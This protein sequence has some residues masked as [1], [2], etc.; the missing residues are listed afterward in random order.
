MSMSIDSESYGSFNGSADVPIFY[1]HI[2]AAPE[3]GRILIAHGL[4]EHSGRYHHVMERL[5]KKGLS[6]WALDHRGHGQSGGKR[7]H[8]LAFDHFIED[9]QQMMKIV[10]TDMPDNMKCFLLG[11][12]M[13]GLIVLNYAEKHPHMIDGLI[14]SSPGL[15]PA[16]GIPLIK[17][18]AG[19]IMSK[20]R[21]SMALNNEVDSRFLSHDSTVVSD[22][23]N[24]PLVHPWITAR[25]FT[26]YVDAMADTIRSAPSLKTPILMQV[27]G[28]DHLV[29]P[30]ASRQFFDSLTVSD[31]TLHFYDG[32]YHE[33]YNE[34]PK[35]RERVLGDL[36]QWIDDHL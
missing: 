12:S 11:H 34:T 32:L 1:R 29:A 19:R 16:D 24:D 4:G 15:A 7:G 5:L 33:I 9:L 26:E 36:E 17:G 20:I 30:E 2:Q 18:T 31:K 35:D 21:P 28:D 22:Y 14:A 25:W 6:V 8:I 27:A 10:K 23:D 13:G 3:R